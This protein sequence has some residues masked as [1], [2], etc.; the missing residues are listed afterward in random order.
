MSTHKVCL[1]EMMR[2]WAQWLGLGLAAI[3]C[4]ILFGLLLKSRMTEITALAFALPV[5]FILGIV[6]WIV[7]GRWIVVKPL[8]Y[9]MGVSFDTLSLDRAGAFAVAVLCITLHSVQPHV[10]NY[11]GNTISSLHHAIPER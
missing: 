2:I 11:A 7:I 10:T 5:G 4:G 6:A 3:P 1:P 8:E 9:T